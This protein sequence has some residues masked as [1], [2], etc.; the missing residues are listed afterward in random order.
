[1]NQEQKGFF[2]EL[3]RRRVL[4]IAGAY[5][6]IAWLIT[7]IASFLL[8]QI[9]APGWALRLLAIVFIVGFPVAVVL[10]WVVQKQPDGKWSVDSSKGQHKTV[11]AALVLGSVAT[12]GLSWLILPNIEDE[13]AG[14][15][16]DPLPNS[17]AILPLA[18]ADAAPNV[19]SVADT[20]YTALLEGLYQSNELTLVRL[21]LN[22]RPKDLEAFGRSVRVE[23][24]LTGR[25]LQ[26]SGGVKIGID[27]LDVGRGEI[28]WSQTFDWDPTRIMDMGTDIANGV[29]EAMALPMLSQ[30]RFAGTDRQEAYEAFLSGMENISS[31][32]LEDLARAMEDIQ[33]AIGLDPG[34]VLAY[35][36]LSIASNLYKDI[37]GPPEAERQALEDRVRQALETALELDSESAAAVSMLGRMTENRELKIQAYQHALELDPNHAF[38]YFR[39]GWEMYVDG[40]LDEAERL[41]RRALELDPMDSNIRAELADLLIHLERREDAVA[42]IEKSIEIQP[43]MPLNYEVLGRMEYFELGRL[44]EA[45]SHFRTAYSLDP[46]SGGSASFVAVV[47]AELGARGE[48]LAWM[49]RSL[50]LSP[51]RWW[52]QMGSYFA[53]M[54]LGEEE[55]ALEHVE[56]ALELAPKL[57]HALRELGARDIEAGRM[58]VALER[59]QQAFPVLTTSDDPVINLS[60]IVVATDYLTNLAQAGQSGRARLLAERSLPVVEQVETRSIQRDYTTRIS[61]A[62]G[63]KEQALE[64]LQ[65]EI[66]DGNRRW[67][68]FSFDQAEFD[69]LRDEPEFQRLM[70]IASTDKAEQLKRIRAM[71]RNGELPPA[72]GV[73]IEPSTAQ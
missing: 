16:Y 42:E 6:A 66:V 1:M 45:I 55:A 53:L 11:I 56:R 51:T 34:Y 24:L 12:V 28:R 35:V 50:Q 37:K 72:P 9:N 26:E 62:L 21:R 71:E 41:W 15:P 5:I 57:S 17:V 46:E 23:A 18:D 10:A 7:E 20:L 13:P 27:L 36:H 52:A 73:V 8:G 40:K 64:A 38:S 69:F 22:N 68:L 39:L 61:A 44:A 70:D 43:E 2:S 31:Y 58:Q 67:G 25:I 54:M 47:Y 19:Q 4:P 33:R 63:Q 14:E 48:A 32:R 29:L 49:E 30:Q 65:K 60:N 59:W 3:R